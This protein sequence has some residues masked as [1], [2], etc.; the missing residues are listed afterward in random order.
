MT[1][2]S[3]TIVAFDCQMDHRDSASI[4]RYYFEPGPTEMR[5][6]YQKL[7]IFAAIPILLG[8]FIASFWIPY[9]YWK[10]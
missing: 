7:M 1:S 2:S 9:L 8:L 5:I 10:K 6:T 3:D 4:D